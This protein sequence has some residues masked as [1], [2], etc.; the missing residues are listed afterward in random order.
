V[1]R[2]ASAGR[3]PGRGAGGPGLN[4]ILAGQP[5]DE[6]LLAEL[7]DLEHDQIVED[8]AFYASWA[9]RRPAAV[10]DLGCG[11]GRLFRALVDGGAERIVGID[12]SPALLERAAARIQGDDHLRAAFDAGR[13]EL[14]AGDVRTVAR[15]ERFSLVIIAGVLAHLDGPEDALRTLSAAAGLLAPDGVLIVDTLGP[16]ALPSEDLP[17][18][19]DWERRLGA[20]RVV[21]RSRLDRHEAPEGLRV[22][23]STL[24][25]LVEADG[26][27]TRLPASFRLWYPSIEVTVALAAE[28]NL[29]VVAA[30]GSHDLGPLD[31]RSERC[32][33][34]MG[35]APNDNRPGTG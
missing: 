30:F 19:L 18:S 20:R 14:S 1:D 33:V 3:R 9:A 23:Y 2:A 6:R 5:A 32:I 10:L 35:S 28:A 26:T 11:S 17:L 31:E 22:G 27:I 34:V 15:P 21:R 13:I 4:D 25:D 24:T 29:E 16:A 12:G 8:L 7:Y